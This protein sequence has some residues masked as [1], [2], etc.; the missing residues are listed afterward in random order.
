M[1]S[2]KAVAV[3]LLFLSST[4]FAQSVSVISG[5]LLGHDGKPMRK[6]QVEVF[7][8]QQ[9]GKAATTAPAD[10]QGD[11]TLRFEHTGL[12][13]LRCVGVNHYQHMIPLWIEPPVHEKLTVRLRLYE[14]VDDFSEV[15]I[16]GDFNEY[17]FNSAEPMARQS[18]GT[19]VF[20][21]ETEA[22]T[23]A[24]QL[25]G[26]EKTERSING[27]Q[28]DDWVY[29]NGGDYRSVVKVTNKKVKVVFDPAKL[30]RGKPGDEVLVRFDSPNS[31]SSRFYVLHDEQA[32]RREQYSRTYEAFENAHGDESEG[33]TFD[34]KPALAALKQQL[35]EEKNPNLRQVLL[36]D[37][38]EIGS[39]NGREALDI[40]L[41]TQAFAEISPTCPLWSNK[42]WLLSEST[43]WLNDEIKQDKYLNQVLA[44]HPDRRLCANIL[45]SWL[46][47]ADDK[48]DTTKAKTF[49]DRLMADFADTQ[50]AMWARTQYN[51]DRA[52]KKGKKL[53][54]FA[55]AALEQNGA[56]YNNDSMKGK[57]YLLDFW[58]VWCGP[59][60]GEMPAL[61]AAY[62]KFH[63][64]NFEILSLSFDPKPEDVSKFRTKK[65][66]MPWRHAF[67]KGGFRSELA[68]SFEVMGIPKPILIDGSTNTI[69][70]TENELRGEKLE[71]TL[72]RV[73][74]KP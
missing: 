45:M 49:Y 55:I 61:H 47:K 11:F 37:A 53:P 39:M 25:L 44:Q 40:K 24:Y 5:K 12:L 73:L 35:S 43:S 17:D 34:W 67:V 29:D 64:K 33:F 9:P 19:Y 74:A 59:C 38:L 6:A 72:A 1:K 68:Q 60:I 41:I 10:A 3:A 32:K 21:T 66:K 7:Y 57:I 54:A 69:L 71:Q 48:D 8:T 31:F 26:V 62:E 27:T 52:I 50:E 2:R 30:P 46:A 15:R 22:D 14:Y 56:S 42:P 18:D 51:P 36:L 63:N 28:S 16:L 58:A 20:E 23:F 4:I 13:S 70:A 65:W